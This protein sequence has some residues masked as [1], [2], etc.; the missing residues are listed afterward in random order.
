MKRKKQGRKW[1]Q[2]GDDSLGDFVGT[3]VGKSDEF[4]QLII[5]ALKAKKMSKDD[6]NKAV[7]AHVK[8]GASPAE[9][10][11][12]GERML[13]FL[14]SKNV[15]VSGWSLFKSDDDKFHELMVNAIK[16]KKIS[17]DDFNKSVILN[18]GPKATP[19]AKEQSAKQMLQIL[20]DK[21]VAVS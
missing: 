15:A 3:F 1:G 4:K 17:R 13:K 11:A 12:A 14:G 18:V 20:A 9:R 7:A 16:T 21:G 6:F 2:Q 10:T 8:P 5:A 19:E